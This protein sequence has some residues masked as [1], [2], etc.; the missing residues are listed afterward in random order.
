M[1]SFRYRSL[2]EGLYT[3]SKLIEALYSLNSLPVVSFNS[4]LG[5]NWL[6]PFVANSSKASSSEV[7]VQNLGPWGLGFK[8]LRV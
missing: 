6:G 2:I 3:F 1:G 7:P 8:G 4:G 5:R